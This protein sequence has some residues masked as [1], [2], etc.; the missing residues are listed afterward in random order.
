MPSVQ[1]KI[2]NIKSMFLQKEDLG[3]TIYEYQIDEITEGDE[4][5]VEQGL[6][7][8]EGEIRSYLSG[9]NKKEWLDGRLRYDV[10][11]ILNA[12]GNQREPIIVRLG[13]TIAKWYII[14]VCN[15]EVIAD[16]A[17]KRYD[18]AIGFLKKLSSGELNLSTL[19]VISE[20]I[21]ETSENDTSF[22]W[23]SRAKFIHE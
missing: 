21:E 13:A 10:D 18:R 7:A 17:E 14:D 22:V 19:P 20:N 12:T 4:S 6:L 16:H 5:I 15:T 1:L 9:N 2:E 11:A 8:A 23:G 3:S